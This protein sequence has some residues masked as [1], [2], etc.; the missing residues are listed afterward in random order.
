MPTLVGSE[1]GYRLRGRL[2]TWRSVAR[3]HRLR[4]VFIGIGL[5]GIAFEA[6]AGSRNGIV[7]VA[8]GILAALQ[9]VQIM[10]D[11]REVDREGSRYF[12]GAPRDTSALDDVRLSDRYVGFERFVA[13]R[14]AALRSPQLD[15]ALWDGADQ[16]IALDPTPWAMPVL[17]GRL[18]HFVLRQRQRSTDVVYDSAKV[19][20]RTDLSVTALAPDAPPIR[21]QRT[22][23]FASEVTNE[24]TGRVILERGTD[25]VVYDGRS[26][27]VA[28][29]V[30]RDLDEGAL[31]NHIGVS[32]LA[33][34]SDGFLILTL[35]SPGSAQDPT[36]L[37]PSGSGSADLE[38]ADGVTT[39]AALVL[40]AMDRELA[41]EC[42]L[43]REAITTR[44][45]G[46][47]RLLHRGGKPDLFGLSRLSVP[48]ADVHV[49]EAERAFVSTHRSVR[50]DRTDAAALRASLAAVADDAANGA[51]FT[52]RLALRIVDDLL[53]ER[54]DEVLAFLRG[55]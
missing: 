32:T 5:V 15:V 22:S 28:G 37:V 19:G 50:L 29:D 13:A 20:L 27:A 21:T 3:R 16:R 40:A 25:A 4:I 53:A 18:L 39:L 42:G 36:G 14:G 6:L 35:Q 55:A 38:D 9:V 24:L 31:S 17:A 30:L 49:V 23:Y 41:E 43:P 2:Q 45:C 44:L 34:T 46:Y 8:G 11:L 48:L 1:R 47:A 54:P 12:F 51:S 7:G 52:L 26:M 10:L 33:V